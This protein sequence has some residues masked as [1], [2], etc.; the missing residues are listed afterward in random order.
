M[1]EEEEDEEE[2]GRLQ[3][4]LQ[5]WETCRGYC[6]QLGL[7]PRPR[8]LDGSRCNYT[9]R[10]WDDGYWLA[11]HAEG[12]ITRPLTGEMRTLRWDYETKVLLDLS[13]DPHSV[14]GHVRNYEVIE[15]ICVGLGLNANVFLPEHW[16]TVDGHGMYEG[17]LVYWDHRRSW[18]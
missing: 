14:L 9:T 3:I 17:E 4:S 13:T 12:T 10:H 18:P 16:S 2:E 8:W 11:N 6:M 15:E 5:G 7:T 1:E